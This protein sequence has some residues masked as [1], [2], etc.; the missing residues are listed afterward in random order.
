VLVDKAPG[1]TS[2]DVV[3]RVRRALGERRAG[4]TGTLDPFATGLLVVLLGRATRIARFVE[5]REKGYLAVARLGLR[6]T[7]DDATGE[8]MTGDPG[9]V[10]DARL[11]EALAQLAA[12]TEQRPPAF[13][14][15][16]VGGQR[17]YRLARQGKPPELPARAVTVHSLELLGREGAD[18]TFRTV[19]S[20]GTYVRAMARDLGE[21]LGTGA[22][23]TALRRESI[24]TL[25]VE[26]ATPMDQLDAGTAVL[27]PLAMVSHLPR[28]EV[29]ADGAVA[30]RHGRPVAAGADLSADGPVA[31]VQGGRLLAIAEHVEDW[32]RPRVVLED[33]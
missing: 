29:D 21:I 5:Q 14:A 15:R 30:I 24:G 1:P 28:R 13:S 18:I 27:P 7:T 6:T 8:P 2:H 3:A 17:S 19:V 26:D 4:H 33:A 31:L 32:L 9:Q 16:Q 25:R 10:G 20:P 23:L 11:S 22:H 12:Q